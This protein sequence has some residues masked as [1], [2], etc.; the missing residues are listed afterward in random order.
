MHSQQSLRLTTH[1]STALLSGPGAAAACSSIR[2]S[3]SSRLQR[4]SSPGFGAAA[5]VPVAFGASVRKQQY[6]RA[7]CFQGWEVSQQWGG[8]SLTI[9]SSP[10]VLPGKQQQLRRIPRSQ[11]DT[12]A[13]SLE[14]LTLD[15]LDNEELEDLFETYGE[16]V[17]EESAPTPS[18]S[19]VDDDAESLALAVAL[20]EVANDV[21]ASEIRVLCVKPLVYWTRFFVIATGFSRPQVDAIGQR[22]RNMAAERFKRT[23]QGDLKPNAWTLLDFGDVVV[24]IFYPNERSFYNLEEFYGNAISVELPFESQSQVL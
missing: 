14:D 22:M 5:A 3:S 11:A 4:L 18:S 19:E 13:D 1:S 20:A 16:V 12:E 2:G 17:R 7:H 23:A 24:H 8:E 9:Q 15:D 6:F 10:R 21:K